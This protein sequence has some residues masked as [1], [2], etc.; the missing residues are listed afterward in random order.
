MSRKPSPWTK[1]SHRRDER[2]RVSL[3]ASPSGRPPSASSSS[4][5]AMIPSS[6][7]GD[8]A[9]GSVPS[10]PGR[11]ARLAGSCPW[12]ALACLLGK[13]W[14][15]YRVGRHR[16]L[17][18]FIEETHASQR[19]I[20]FPDALRNARSADA[21]LWRGSPNPPFVQRVGAWMFGLVF[22]GFGLLSFPLAVRI[23][24]EDRS[25]FG[26]VITALIGISLVLIG[27]RIFRNG[28]PRHSR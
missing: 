25:R 16:K 23:L 19:N 8:S 21:F 11:P 28:F 1:D 2:F 20:V 22:M 12:G 14:Y 27:I 26:F 3:K 24:R 17:D 15:D 6:S 5:A 18:K 10:T 13:A 7:S 4:S 9:V